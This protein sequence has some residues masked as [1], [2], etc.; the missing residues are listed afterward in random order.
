M[1][2][3]K[4]YITLIAFAATVILVLGTTVLLTTK[5][6]SSPEHSAVPTSET[7]HEATANSLDVERWGAHMDVRSYS[8]TK[9]AEGAVCSSIS[10]AVNAI[11]SHIASSYTVLDDDAVDTNHSVVFAPT[12]THR[13]MQSIVELK[14]DRSRCEQVARMVSDGGDI[15]NETTLLGRG[16]GT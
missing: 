9:I 11:R 1:G 6:N 13:K 4:Q 15:E 12:G 7:T 8:G 10:V 14:G 2:R 16:D 3:S 5:N